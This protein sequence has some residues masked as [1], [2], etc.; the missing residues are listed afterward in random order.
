MTDPDLI[1]YYTVDYAIPSKITI[2][3]CD[4]IYLGIQLLDTCFL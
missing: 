1:G 4:Q 2:K 3:Y